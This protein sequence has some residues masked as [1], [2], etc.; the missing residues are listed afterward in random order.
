M[1]PRTL[2]KEAKLTQARLK[3]LFHYTTETGLFTRLVASGRHGR[4]RAGEVAGFRR[5][6]S[7]QLSVDGEEYRA[8]RLAWLYMKGEWPADEIDHRDGDPFNNRWDNLR[9]ATSGQNKQNSAVRKDSVS[10]VKGVRFDPSRGKWRAYIKVGGRQI[11]LGR[12]PSL[13]EAAEAYKTAKAKHH[14][15][16]PTVRPEW[17]L[18][19]RTVGA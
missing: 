6:A 2:A 4:N 12:F 3:V 1:D 8:H 9:E 19:T 18:S 16:Q 10:G 15:F 13:E 14:L 17:D 7:V 11:Y 5:E